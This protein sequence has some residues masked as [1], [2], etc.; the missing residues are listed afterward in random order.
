[1]DREPTHSAGHNPCNTG[2]GYTRFRIRGSKRSAR[3]ALCAGELPTTG[4]LAVLWPNPGRPT[5]APGEGCEGRPRWSWAAVSCHPQT[6]DHRS[7]RTRLTERTRICSLFSLLRLPVN[8]SCWFLRELIHALRPRN[9]SLPQQQLHRR[10][11][12]PL[13]PNLS[14][15]RLFLS[16]HSSYS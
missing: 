6:V 11:A 14:S 13:L 8:P 1:M 7:Q 15:Q 4:N 3:C 2:R 16:S 5:R 12:G 10:G 9:G